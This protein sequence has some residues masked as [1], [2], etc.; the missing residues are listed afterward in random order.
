MVHKTFL[1]RGAHLHCI[2]FSGCRFGGQLVQ[3]LTRRGFKG[4]GLRQHGGGVGKF[5]MPFAFD[6]V[7]FL[8][9]GNQG[10]QQAAVWTAEG[11]VKITAVFA[12]AAEQ[13]G[14]L[15]CR[16]IR[17]GRVGGQMIVTAPAQGAFRLLWIFRLL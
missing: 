7:P 10:Q 4:D 9:D 13:V 8:I 16:G 6:K 11:V 14:T 5:Q 12:G 2:G 15:P 17:A 1:V 3:H